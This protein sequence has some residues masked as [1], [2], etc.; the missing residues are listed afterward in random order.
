MPTAKYIAKT[1]GSFNINPQNL[2]NKELQHAIRDMA[3]E[4]NK[5]LR[6]LETQ[7]VNG[8]LPGAYAYNSP[9]Y[10]EVLSLANQDSSLMARKLVDGE[11]TTVA[12]FTQTTAGK[13]RP[14]LLRQYGNLRGFM[15][16]DTRKTKKVE[17]YYGNLPVNYWQ[18]RES[19]YYKA[20]AMIYGSEQATNYYSDGIATPDGSQSGNTFTVPAIDK[21]LDGKNPFTNATKGDSI[22]GASRQSAPPEMHWIRR[23]NSQEYKVPRTQEE[24][25]LQNEGNLGNTNLGI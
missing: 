12:R 13:S 24:E 6:A 5:N 20:Y 7:S 10:R 22:M 14:E 15:G 21:I 3:Q 17:E 9:F 18:L 8:S 2:T 19:E 4:L 1:N 11:I 25:N 23:L 16:W